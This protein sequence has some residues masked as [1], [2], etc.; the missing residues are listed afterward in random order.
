[1]KQIFTKPQLVVMWLSGLIVSGILYLYSTKPY[2]TSV[3]LPSTITDRNWVYLD[4][5]QAYIIPIIIF[6]V[7]LIITLIPKKKEH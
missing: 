1:M 4:W 7:L 5:F 2:I 3:G 6:A